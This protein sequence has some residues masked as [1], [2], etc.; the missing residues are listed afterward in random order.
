MAAN[1]NVF[2]RALELQAEGPDEFPFG[3]YLYLARLESEVPP[4]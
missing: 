3:Y 1:D 4:A 2:D